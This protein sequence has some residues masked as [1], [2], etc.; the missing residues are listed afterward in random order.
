MILTFL[1]CRN[2]DHIYGYGFR[3]DEFYVLVNDRL[4]PGKKKSLKDRIRKSLQNASCN[5]HILNSGQSVHVQHDQ[6]TQHYCGFGKL[7]S[8][9]SIYF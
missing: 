3:P 2:A 6:K 5:I 7:L 1:I 9:Y 4:P 8:H